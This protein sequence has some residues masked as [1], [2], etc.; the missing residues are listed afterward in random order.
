MGRHAA[1][2]RGRHVN[3]GFWWGNLKERG[4]LEDISI[5]GRIIYL[6]GIYWC[7]VDQCVSGQV[8]V[9]CCFEHGNEPV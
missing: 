3:V 6:Y 5:D 2:M 8:Q 1:R 4:H 9:A 7:G